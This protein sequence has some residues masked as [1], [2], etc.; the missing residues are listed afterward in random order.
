[1]SSAIFS[2]EIHPVESQQIQ[3]IH[4]Q[5]SKR[6]M[7]IVALVVVAH[8][9]ILLGL[10]LVRSTIN[11]VPAQTIAVRM[12]AI[13]PEQP[14]PVPPKPVVKPKEVPIVKA[15][16]KP[17]PLPI[18]VAPKTAKSPVSVPPVEKAIEKPMD[19]PP[20]VVAAPP[21]PAAPPQKEEPAPP[22]MVEGVAY[23]K[24]P[25]PIY[26]DAARASG[27]TGK[28]IVRA[29]INVNGLVDDV[30]VKKTSGS[31]L[32]DRAAMQAVKKARFK[33]YRENG[34]AQA[35]YTLIPIEFNLGQD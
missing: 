22:K 32:L 18:L 20:P 29:L 24:Q 11:V 6:T 12:V 3:A 1:M 25:E 14:K 19:N 34:V 10:A 5:S 26:P 33:P 27:D 17:K 13:V 7:V 4:P 30:S 35:V 8:G 21:V 31:A 2:A 28:T 9:L 23:L 15:L 16:P